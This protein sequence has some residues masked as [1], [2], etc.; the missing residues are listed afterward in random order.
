MPQNP[1]KNRTNAISTFC[2]VFK[3]A[4]VQESYCEKRTMR[5]LDVVHTMKAMLHD[6]RSYICTYVYT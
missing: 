3:T 2:V 1:Q 5:G 6:N 4:L